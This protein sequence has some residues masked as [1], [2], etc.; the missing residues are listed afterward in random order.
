MLICTEHPCL[1][2]VK[3]CSSCIRIIQG[4]V[5]LP[6]L[7]EFTL[8]SKRANPGSWW[9]TVLSS[10]LCSVLLAPLAQLLRAGPGHCPMVPTLERLKNSAGSDHCWELQGIRN[11]K[12]QRTKFFRGKGKKTSNCYCHFKLEWLKNCGYMCGSC[13]SP[14]S[15]LKKKAEALS[16]CHEWAFYWNF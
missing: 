15:W 7:G 10:L 16:V 13:S 14:Q 3:S 9:H 5:N 12:N 11:T 1:V 4:F 2:A 8:K 6:I